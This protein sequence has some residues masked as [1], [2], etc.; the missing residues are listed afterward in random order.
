MDNSLIS[1]NSLSIAF[2]INK[3][4]KIT[5]NKKMPK[6]I[7]LFILT[8]LFLS[9]FANQTKA[10]SYIYSDGRL[11]S[12]FIN[13]EFKG[14]DYRVNTTVIQGDGKILIGGEFNS[15]N[16][17]PANCIARLNTEGSLDTDFNIGTGFNDNGDYKV[18]TI[19]LQSDGKILVGGGFTSYNGTTVNHIV[20]LNTD[21]SLDTDFNIGVGFNSNVMGMGLQS[22][23]KIV[24]IGQFSSYNGTAVS[25]IARLNTNGTLDTSF[26]IGTGFN[27]WGPESIFIQD[28]NK[29]VIGGLFTTF[30][31]VTRNEI[32]RLNADGTLDTT[33]DPGTGLSGSYYPEILDI[34]VQ[35]DGKIIIVG[36]R[37]DTYRGTSIGYIARIN[38]DG[39]LDTDFHANAG[40]GFTIRT[41]SVAIQSDGK[42]LI[43]GDFDSYNGTTIKKI[44]RLNSNGTLDNTFTSPSKIYSWMWVR[45]ISIQSDNKIIIGGDYLERLNSDGSLDTS[46]N[47]GAKGFNGYISIVTTQD[48]GKILV[49][50]GFT[51]YNDTA[52]N[53][54]ARLNVDGSLDETFNFGGLGFDDCVN[55][56]AL[57][58]DGKIL[59]GGWFTSYNGTTANNI[60]RLNSDGSLDT[61]FNSGGLGFDNYINTIAL[62]SDGKILVGGDFSSYNGN[63]ANNIAR[64]NSDGSIDASFNM[65]EGFNGDWERVYF[66]TIQ[67]D[68]KILVG[69]YFTI[70]NGTEVNNIVRLNT[71][72]SMDTTFNQGTGFG[73]DWPAVCSIALQNDGKI[74]VGG[75]FNSYNGVMANYIVRLNS[76]GSL[77]ETFSSG[78]GLG[79]DYPYI[80]TMS[81]QDDG[82]ILIGGYFTSYNGTAVN[83]IVRLNSDGSLDETF[84]SG[85]GLAGLFYAG[86]YSVFF[87]NDNKILVG[88]FFT[89]YNNTEVTFLTRLGLP[90]LTGQITINSGEE[91]IITHDVILNFQATDDA[92]AVSQMM[93]CNN[94]EFTDCDWRTYTSAITWTLDS[95]FG[96]KTVYVKFKDALGNITDVY[97]DSIMIVS[98]GNPLPPPNNNNPGNN[99]NNNNGN[100]G[101][102]NPGN[103]QNNNNNNNNSANNNNDE[104]LEQ[105]L[106]EA[107]I[108]ATNDKNQLLTHLAIQAD[109]A[110]EQQGLI[111][112]QTILNLDKTI[113]DIERSTINNFIVY[114]TKSTLRLGSGERAAVIN[115]YYKA[116]SRLPNSEAEWSDLLKIANGR[117]PI[118]RNSNIEEQAKIEFSRVYGR[119]PVMSNNLDQN[120]IMVMAY[121]LMPRPRNLISEQTAI[122]TFKWIYEHSPV[123]ATDWNIIRGIAYSGLQR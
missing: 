1:L 42:I 11:D 119:N 28:D 77:D 26:N 75:G 102:N 93:V 41:A 16:G 66:V 64:L 51:S 35:S 3:N 4:M 62:Q 76:D 87:Q 50:G 55:T 32:A 108:L 14:V 31:G 47:P 59:V 63:L 100:P 12:D 29:I 79:N 37:I 98:G 56:I 52:V 104:L 10:Q 8:L 111:K 86:V 109:L 112:Y 74:L 110:K 103:N 105:I 46:F 20:R 58:S 2:L 83:N 33:F 6:G 84:N 53:Y 80:Q 107:Q 39:S 60:V 36:M 113:T 23:G 96:T 122:T 25:R 90:V 72:G 17:T 118:E 91:K 89:S 94:Q 61:T 38:T 44:A 85:T 24:V 70:Y 13:G 73:G 95:G 78:T 65:E 18:E 92:G 81:L 21:G 82:K 67:N 19:V 115:S 88:G 27:W 57:Q 117:W 15:Y 121:G 101:N 7:I 40:T 45:D 120:T 43:G 99:G 69:G 68:D 5:K 116:Y 48:D 54:I 123:N 30:N 9:S 22:D 97:S 34:A 114:G 49:G 71:D 106:T